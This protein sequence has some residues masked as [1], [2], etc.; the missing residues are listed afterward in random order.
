MTKGFVH[1]T[2][3]V[4]TGPWTMT[5]APR[6]SWAAAYRG[7]P[8]WWPWPERRHEVKHGCRNTERVNANYCSWLTFSS[9]GAACGATS[10]VGG[11]SCGEGTAGEGAGELSGPAPRWLWSPVHRSDLNTFKHVKSQMNLQIFINLCFSPLVAFTSIHV[12][13]SL[14][15]LLGRLKLNVGVA[16][17][18]V[19]VD[20]VHGHVDHLDLAVD[21]EDLL[22][23]VLQENQADIVSRCVA[24][25]H[26]HTQGKGFMFNVSRTY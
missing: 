26:Q 11:A 7:A 15:R 5:A 4:G 23:V 16:F 1:L 20:T 19:R 24:T 12:F 6:W 18:Q 22:D 8:A 17:G 2:G 3:R 25:C 21:G 10:E 14:F 9:F 13:Q